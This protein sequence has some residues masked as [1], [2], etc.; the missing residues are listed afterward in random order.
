MTFYARDSTPGDGVVDTFGVPF[1]YIDKAHVHVSLD[2]VMV[3]DGLLVWL[4]SA[5]IKLP[6]PPGAGVIVTRYRAT[7]P[8][9]PFSVFTLGDLDPED[10]NV[11]TLQCLYC[12]AEALDAY[13]ASLKLDLEDRFDARG[14]RLINLGDG[15][16]PQDAVTVSQLIMAVENGGLGPSGTVSHQRTVRALAD[17]GNPS[18]V[19]RLGDV[20][21]AA[22]PDGGNAGAADWIACAPTAPGGPK[23]IFIRDTCGWNDT[24]MANF[25]TLARSLTL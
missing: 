23:A 1:P 19:S 17:P 22:D 21:T 12:V 11:A 24:Q 3:D 20:I 13:E 16:D 6:S 10:L 7:P 14:R 9:P 15:V 4:D 25:L 18:G 2:G 5:T 8:V